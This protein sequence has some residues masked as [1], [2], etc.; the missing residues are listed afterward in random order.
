MADGLSRAAPLVATMTGSTMSG[1]RFA[2]LKSL[3]TTRMISVE[4]NMPVLHA[5]GRKFG[6]DGFDLLGDQLCLC[7][8][9]A[10]HAARILRGEAGN[11][12]RAVN[13]ERGERLQIGLNA[14]AAAAVGAGDGQR[15]GERGTLCHAE[16]IGGEGESGNGKSVMRDA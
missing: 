2:A 8:L 15:D 5:V 14:R 12:T 3:V 13:A 1:G 4:N 10:G 9:N 11:R 7:G 16:T 6:E